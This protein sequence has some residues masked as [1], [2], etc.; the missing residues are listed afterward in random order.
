M[1]T[2]VDR[3][4]ST[5]KYVR[6]A[7]DLRR[8]VKE[9][10]LKPGDQLPSFV[11]LRNQHQVSRGTV[12]KV[13]E[14]LERDGLIVRE[15]G[16]GVFVAYPKQRS[17]SGVIALA[18]GGFSETRVS[19]FW[20]HLMSGIQESA[21]EHKLQLL[22]VNEH[23]ENSVLERVD[24]LL[25]SENEDDLY[26]TYARLPQGLPCVSMLTPIEELS[27]VRPDDTQGAKDATRHLL[28]LGHR[29]IGHLVSGYQHLVEDRLIGYRQAMTEYGIEPH[30][31]WVRQL[32]PRANSADSKAE[33][34]EQGRR[35][36]REWLRTDWKESRCTAIV[37]QNDPAAIGAIEELQSAGI[38]VPEDV[39]IVGYDG[40]EPYDY[41]TPRLTTVE[42]PAKDVGYT[43][44]ELL[45]KQIDSKSAEVSH[46]TLPATLRIGE[47][48]AAVHSV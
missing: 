47:S 31:A 11:E 30:L 17:V 15:L 6:L 29:R 13:H 10:R 45:F 35:T 46:I 24:G 20:S 21:L 44:L 7:Q 14:M 18:G 12:E 16:R 5:A 3:D 33:F 26:A 19:L 25:L 8:Q 43:A 38:R 9:G 37:V 39:S 36:I 34:V 28:S 2:T 1:S 4:P 48:T 32:R 22:L 41:F 23:V 27:C 42:V 40:I